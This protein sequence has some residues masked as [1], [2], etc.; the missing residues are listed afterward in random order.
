M[1]RYREW[2]CYCLDRCCR[3]YVQISSRVLVGP[4]SPA[5]PSIHTQP[6]TSARELCPQVSLAQSHS[7]TLVEVVLR[8]LG[9]DQLIH[10]PFSQ[11]TPPR[12]LPHPTMRRMQQ[13]QPLQ[14]LLQRLGL[15]R[16]KVLHLLRRRR[17]PQPKLSNRNGRCLVLELQLKY[18]G[19]GLDYHSRAWGVGTCTANGKFSL[20]ANALFH[21]PYNR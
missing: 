20:I 5:S 10:L 18:I 9:L 11:A 13:L 6:P 2:R 15:E 17:S 14:R 21:L 19:R 7:R 4:A 3:H 12:S 1:R 8:A 16:H